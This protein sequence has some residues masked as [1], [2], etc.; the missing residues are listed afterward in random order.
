MTLHN[1]YIESIRKQALPSVNQDPDRRQASEET[2][3]QK[4]C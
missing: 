1:V 4:S 2:G 3:L